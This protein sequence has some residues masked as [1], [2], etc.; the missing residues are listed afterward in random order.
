METPKPRSSV[1]PPE[2]FSSN[3][4]QDFFF[5]KLFWCGNI[6]FSLLCVPAAA[7]PQAQSGA[8]ELS[9]GG[10]IL[11]AAREGHQ[12]SDFLFLPLVNGV[13]SLLDAQA[14]QLILQNGLTLSDLDRNPE[15]SG[16]TEVRP[17]LT[18]LSPGPS[19]SIQAP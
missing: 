8:V 10:S 2:H 11:A 3:Q 5:I 15:V 14:R 6:I 7:S 19:G 16:T 4:Q 1:A 12:E 17:Q 9:Q 18:F 13:C